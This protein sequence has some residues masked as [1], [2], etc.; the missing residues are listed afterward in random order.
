V[1]QW[2][3]EE[4]ESGNS[5]TR[6]LDH[7]TTRPLLNQ[8]GWAEEA[9]DLSWLG[10]GE[11]VQVKI[12]FVSDGDTVDEGFYIDDVRVTGGGPP[13]VAIAGVQPA[14]GP[15]AGLDVWPSPFRRTVRIQ[16][17]STLGHEPPQLSVYDASG[18]MVRRLPSVW[19]T[20]WDGRN[21]SGQLL[22]AGA[23]FIEA[24]TRADRRL[25]KVLLAR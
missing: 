16:C 14:P 6:P 4:P 11:T 24:R 20:T 19:S 17:G 1:S 18:R 9:Y 10:L 2:S 23:Y 15:V 3:S 13:A 12:A 25:V 8:S 21:G 7:S 5:A 22:P